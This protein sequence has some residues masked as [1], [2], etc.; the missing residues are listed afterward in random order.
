MLTLLASHGKTVVYEVDYKRYVGAVIG[1]YNDKGVKVG[2]PTH[3]KNKEYIFVTD[4]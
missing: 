3:T 2:T 4:F 1:I